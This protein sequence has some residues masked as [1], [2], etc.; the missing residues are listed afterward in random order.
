MFANENKPEFLNAG[1]SAL[2]VVWWINYYAY[3]LWKIIGIGEEPTGTR[4][5]IK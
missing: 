3:E 2:R 5:I 1:G 4:V